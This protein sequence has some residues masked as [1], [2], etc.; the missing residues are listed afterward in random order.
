MN[1]GIPVAS[2]FGIEVRVSVSLAVMVGVVALLGADQAVLLSPELA[3]P[4][5]W[6]VGAV[7]AVLYLL[8]VLVHE[9]THALVGRS[10]GIATRAIVLNLVGG[11]APLSIEAGRPRDE[12]A[13]AVS[14]PMASLIIAAVLLPGAVAL[15]F[16]VTTFDVASSA[17]LV[18][19]VLNLMLG[20][21]SLLPALPLDGGRLVRGIAWARTGDRDRASA[22]AARVG[23]LLGW[24]ISLIGLVLLLLDDPILGVM[25]VAMGW[26]L[27]GTSRGLA[28]RAEL[29]RAMR[30]LTVADAL[31][32][33]VPHVGPGL[34]VDTFAGQLGNDGAPRAMPVLDGEHVLGVI[35]LGALRRLGA[36]RLSTARVGDVMATP[37]AAPLVRVEDAIW[38][39]METMQRR[40]LDGLAVVE[41]GH[42]VGMVTRDSAA[43]AMRTR[44]PA[45]SPPAMPFW[46]GR[47]R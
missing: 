38:G 34:T 26:L 47:R 13:I 15:N 30:G 6:V 12:V 36:K 46:R 39:V 11:L 25:L 3:G 23:R 7:V 16:A 21:A 2:L 28:Q 43:A 1:G 42:L 17:L 27:G 8:S 4:A 19:G 14:G 18:I 40:G 37:P 45:V 24:A 33:D 22:T 10:R 9:M 29:E 5:Q 31:L 32:R 35:G 44:L 20:L 41:D